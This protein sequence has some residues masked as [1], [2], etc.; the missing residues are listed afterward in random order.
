MKINCIIDGGRQQ[1]GNRNKLYQPSLLGEAKNNCNKII[2]GLD[3]NS[4]EY[5]GTFRPGE[6][7]VSGYK[8][9]QLL[10]DE[11]STRQYT[12]YEN[13][14][15]RENLYGLEGQPKIFRE[16]ENIYLTGNI[17]SNEKIANENTKS[18][19]ILATKRTVPEKQEYN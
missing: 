3:K 13:Y 18:A 19:S 6:P 2:E 16:S 5:F 14:H 4:S 10:I 12:K 9:N 1:P 7:Q 8:K 11:E 17:Q 15:S